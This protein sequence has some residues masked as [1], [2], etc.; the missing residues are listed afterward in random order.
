MRHGFISVSMLILKTHGTIP[1][2]HKSKPRNWNLFQSQK[3]G[4]W[5]AISRRR[6]VGP[7]FFTTSIN[8]ERYCEIIQQ[9]IAMLELSECYLGF[10]KTVQQ[11]I[12]RKQPWISCERVFRSATNLSWFVT[13]QV[14]GYAPPWIISCK[15]T[16]IKDMVFMKIPN[17]AD[18]LK[19]A[20]TH[21]IHK[22][23][24]KRCFRTCKVGLKLVWK[25]K[26]VILNTFCNV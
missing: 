16:Y 9:F 11:P 24:W 21:L 22:K 5:C 18:E 19:V 3:I 1:V 15:D 2:I 12:L 10:N 13:S 14:A 26:V 20:I 7:F 23:C 8:S 17:T 4:V 25:M 6:I